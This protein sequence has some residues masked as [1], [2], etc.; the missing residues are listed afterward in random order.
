MLNCASYL[1][2][3]KCGDVMSGFLLYVSLRVIKY[4]VVCSLCLVYVEAGPGGEYIG[5]IIATMTDE[6]SKVDWALMFDSIKDN[7]VLAVERFTQE[8]VNSQ[9]EGA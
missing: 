9:T 4:L 3:F 5:N 7:L 1:I 8:T 6:F 2:V